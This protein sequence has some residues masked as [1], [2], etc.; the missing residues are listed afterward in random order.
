VTSKVTAG[1]L[2]GASVWANV[3]NSS[4][5]SFILKYVPGAGQR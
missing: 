5:R 3:Y 1:C 2:S 4:I